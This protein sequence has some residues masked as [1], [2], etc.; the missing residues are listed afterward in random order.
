MCV[1]G[2]SKGTVYRIGR[3]AVTISVV[4]LE[5]LVG[6]GRVAKWESGVSEDGVS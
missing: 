4:F 1:L 2:V 3:T 6:P 5:V